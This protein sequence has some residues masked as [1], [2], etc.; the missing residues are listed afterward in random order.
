MAGLID[1][2]AAGSEEEVEEEEEQQEGKEK[3][4][5][6][7]EDVDSS[8]EDEVRGAS[9]GDEWAGPCC[10]P[11]KWGCIMTNWGTVLWIRRMIQAR[12]G[13]PCLVCALNAPQPDTGELE[14]PCRGLTSTRT[15]VL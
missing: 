6:D 4:A 14:G 13:L 9:H 1:D 8:E 15:T 10:S 5:G 3:S 12:G 2:K 11:G 7:S